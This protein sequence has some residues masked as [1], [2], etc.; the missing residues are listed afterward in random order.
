[1]AALERTAMVTLRMTPEERAMLARLADE[2]GLS[3]SDVLR[4]LLR[5]E[6]AKRDAAK[7]KTK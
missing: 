7:K 2:D 6:H 4:Q 1:M 3:A 5:R